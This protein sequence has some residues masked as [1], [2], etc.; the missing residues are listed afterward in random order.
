MQAQNIKEAYSEENFLHTSSIYFD[1]I[2]RVDGVVKERPIYLRK[3]S[4][5]H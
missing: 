3:G 2:R 5:F 4:N 1:L